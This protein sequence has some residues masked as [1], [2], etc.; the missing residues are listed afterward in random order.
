MKMKA[1]FEC[2]PAEAREFMGL[3]V[4]TVLNDHLTG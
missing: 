1:E 3:P 4:V 2:T